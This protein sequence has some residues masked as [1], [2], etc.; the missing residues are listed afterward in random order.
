[1]KGQPPRWAAIFLY[2]VKNK[3]NMSD[4]KKWGF[5]VVGIICFLY[6]LDAFFPT[7]IYVCTRTESK[8]EIATYAP[9]VPEAMRTNPRTLHPPRPTG[10]TPTAN[11][12]LRNAYNY[13]YPIP[14]KDTIS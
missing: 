1:M 12:W 11:N 5:S 14:V 6:I 10:C 9:D 13:F 4:A 7:W 8:S 2:A 3:A